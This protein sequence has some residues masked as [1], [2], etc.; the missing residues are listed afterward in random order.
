MH[1]FT[2]SG[3]LW[4]SI[5]G[6]NRSYGLQHPPFFENG[7]P[8]IPHAAT[9]LC[10]E[11]VRPAFEERCLD[12]IATFQA[13]DAHPDFSNSCHADDDLWH[14][15]SCLSVSDVVSTSLQS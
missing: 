9:V 11:R 4:R 14:E 7:Q 1:S 6:R 10:R 12:R 8:H 2:L 15:G 13:F 5:C 3:N